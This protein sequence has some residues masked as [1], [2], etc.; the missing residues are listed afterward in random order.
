MYFVVHV[1]PRERFV[2][3]SLITAGALAPYAFDLLGWVSPGFSFSGGNIVIHPRM[4][5][6][7]PIA[8]LFALAYTSIGFVALPALLA[9]RLH[10]ELMLA[11]RQVVMQ[12]W[13]LKR[14]LTR[15]G[16]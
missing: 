2:S 4:V 10:D 16:Q 7:P 13:Q 5:E 12:A 11:Q 6:F 14:L 15:L 9:G 8:S 1:T 3:L